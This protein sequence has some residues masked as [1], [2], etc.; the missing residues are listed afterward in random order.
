MLGEDNAWIRLFSWP[1]QNNSFALKRNIV[2]IYKNI[3][4]I[5]AIVLF[6]A[7]SFFAKINFL[8]KVFI[9]EV[10]FN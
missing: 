10:F 1:I 2:A 7:G 5:L 8:S 3:I 6:V 9:N 4:A